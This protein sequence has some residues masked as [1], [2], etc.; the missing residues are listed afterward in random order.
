MSTSDAVV[1]AMCALVYLAV[2]FEDSW[3]GWE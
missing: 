2:L 1:L 3:G